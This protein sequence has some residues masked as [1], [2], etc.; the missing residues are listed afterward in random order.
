[1]LIHVI[2]FCSLLEKWN[3]TLP[4]YPAYS[5]LKPELSLAAVLAKPFLTKTKQSQFLLYKIQTRTAYEEEYFTYDRNVNYS[6]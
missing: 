4:G 5:T 1:M 2:T 3:S 6:L